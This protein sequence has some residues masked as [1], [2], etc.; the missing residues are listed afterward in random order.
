VVLEHVAKK[1]GL[2]LPPELAARVAQQA[3]GNLRK[4]LLSLEA[5]KVAQ[6][7]FTDDQAVQ[8]T[9][10]ELYLQE[11]TAEILAEQSPKCLLGIRAKLYELLVNCIP[12]ELILK[13]SYPT[14]RT[15]QLPQPPT[16]ER[17]HPAAA[18]GV[19]RVG[20][21]QRLT[22]L[23][24]QKCDAELKHEIC[25]WAAFYEHRL[26]CGQKPVLHLEA[27]VAKFMSVYKRYVINLFG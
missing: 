1:E 26:Q 9:D 12:P 13:V 18:E 21:A 15:P 25:H 22:M 20:S 8:Q 24:M 14:Q 10:W 3:D 23:L 19:S 7:P 5:C 6:Y 17:P 4:A 16:Q 11:V 2:T 27:F